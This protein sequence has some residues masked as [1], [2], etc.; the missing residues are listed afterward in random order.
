[1]KPIGVSFEISPWLNGGQ[2]IDLGIDPIEYTEE[3]LD[4]PISNLQIIFPFLKKL[5]SVTPKVETE[6]K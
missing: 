4:M 5:G 1:M 6:A 2:A 3:D